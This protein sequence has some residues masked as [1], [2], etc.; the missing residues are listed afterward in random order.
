MMYAKALKFS[1]FLLE[2]ISINS[3][4]VY[5]EHKQLMVIGYYW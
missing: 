3:S 4:K 2:Q 5:D 1:S